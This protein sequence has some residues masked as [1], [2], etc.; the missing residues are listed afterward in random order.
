MCFPGHFDLVCQH[1]VFISILEDEIR[2]AAASEL[3]RVPNHGGAVLWC[4]FMYNN[5]QNPDVRAV[6]SAQITRLYPN[7]ARGTRITPWRRCLCAVSQNPFSLCSTQSKTICHSC[8]R[9]YWDFFLNSNKSLQNL[10]QVFQPPSRAGRSI[11]GS[12]FS[13]MIPDI[14]GA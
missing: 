12:G 8:A 3:D 5:A 4:D 13:C 1:T 7:Y 9:I 2:T 14:I 6:R 11:F 10:S